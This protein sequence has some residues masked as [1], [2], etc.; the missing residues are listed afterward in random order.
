MKPMRW[1]DLGKRS[2]EFSMGYRSAWRDATAFLH[3]KAVEMTDPHAT[4]VLN[5]AAFDLGMIKMKGPL[6][7]PPDWVDQVV[8][9][10]REDLTEISDNGGRYT[11]FDDEAIALAIRTAYDK[12]RMT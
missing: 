1:P 7:D 9:K 3:R 10:L 5:A 8:K 11:R 4:Q 12:G 2:V 6:S